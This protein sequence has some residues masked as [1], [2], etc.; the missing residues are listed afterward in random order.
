MQD[1]FDVLQRHGADID[2]LEWAQRGAFGTDY[3][4]ALSACPTSQWLVGLAGRFGLRVALVR[5]ACAYAQT[6][7][8]L[9]PDGLDIPRTALETAERWTRGEVTIHDVRE[10]RDAAYAHTVIAA[11]Y[12]AADAAFGASAVPTPAYYVADAVADA[13]ATHAAAVA[14]YAATARRND[15]KLAEA[16]LLAITKRELGPALLAALAEV[17]A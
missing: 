7:L 5:C 3:E 17:R 6:V 15:R 8:S 1:L 13:I 16:E 10:A 4:T 12:Y 9:V 2:V 11:A 14:D